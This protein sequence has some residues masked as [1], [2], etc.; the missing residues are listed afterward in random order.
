MKFERRDTDNLEL[1]ELTRSLQNV[2]SNISLDNMKT[3]ILEGELG[4]TSSQTFN[5][6]LGQVPALW[7]VVEGDVFVPF[8]GLEK[9]KVTVTSRTATK[10]KLALIK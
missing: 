2:L 7:L 4:A 1:K 6:D 8:G 9:N 10:F 3:R 5:H